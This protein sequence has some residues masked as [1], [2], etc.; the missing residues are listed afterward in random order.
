[1]LEGEALS[2]ALTRTG[3]FPD[4]VI[5]RLSV[6]ENTG[7]V[8]PSL[9]QVASAYQKLISNQLSLFTKVISSGVLMM[10]F[11]FVGFIAFAMVSAIF[12]VSASFKMG[13]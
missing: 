5:D 2:V 4:L 9:K 6:G 11:I 1:V 13:G 8:V 12:N 10:V 7:N 3:C